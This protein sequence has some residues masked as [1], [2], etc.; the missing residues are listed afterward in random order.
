MSQQVHFKLG[1]RIIVET[2]FILT[3]DT[4]VILSSCVSDDVKWQHIQIF[5]SLHQ[6]SIR[7]TWF[8]QKAVPSPTAL[9][10]D[11]LRKKR[12][13][14]W[15]NSSVVERFYTQRP[16]CKALRRRSMHCLPVEKYYTGNANDILN[17]K[18][19]S[20]LPYYSHLLTLRMSAW[21]VRRRDRP[22]MSSKAL[23]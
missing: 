10:K 18:M 21:S 16:D 12:E 8:N 11:C 9:E 15:C 22:S 5:A 4:G 1:E 23:W 17:V 2:G 19:Y 7:L 13:S 6:L 14:W 3:T 20:N